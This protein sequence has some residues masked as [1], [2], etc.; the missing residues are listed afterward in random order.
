MY[1][2]TAW[3]WHAWD[4]HLLE[5]W[6]MD[7]WNRSG[8]Q[9]WSGGVL[10]QWPHMEQWCGVVNGDRS[11]CV[12]LSSSAALGPD[13]TTP[14]SSVVIKSAAFL[15]ILNIWYP[16]WWSYTVLLSCVQPSLGHFIYMMCAFPSTLC[17]SMTRA[18]GEKSSV[19]GADYEVVPESHHPGSLCHGGDISELP[20]PSHRSSPA[21]RST[22]RQVNEWKGAP[23]SLARPGIALHLIAYLDE[24]EVNRIVSLRA[25]A[26]GPL[27][28]STTK[29]ML[30]Q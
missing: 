20:L 27:L 1:S 24:G 28:S 11:R 2:I 5:I 15:R 4:E 26:T 17:S 23:E 8:S 14:W 22:S 9:F 3:I 29:A 7:F 10:E 13:A 18:W 16:D 30:V 21:P 25:C 19:P 6:K 12:Q